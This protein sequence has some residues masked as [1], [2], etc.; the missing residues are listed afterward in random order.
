MDDWN[1]IEAEYETLNRLI[2]QAV[3][4]IHRRYR[5]YVDFDDLKQDCFEWCWRRRRKVEEYLYRDED[6]RASGE[7]A[8]RLALRRRAER[9][10][11]RSKAQAVGYLHT[12]EYFYTRAQVEDLLS[13]YF[14]ED[15]S[16]KLSH[17]EDTERRGRQ[18]PAEGGNV[19]A[20]MADIDRGFKSLLPSDQTLL[21]QLYKRP[22]STPEAL[23]GKDGEHPSPRT[24]R[25]W[26]D[27]AVDRIIVEL[28][29]PSPWWPT[30]AKQYRRDCDY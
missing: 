8:L 2:S 6:G 11:R 10:A 21:I 13:F 3:R 20:L 12:D 26:R 22:T 16:D 15:W 9:A 1:I 28:G 25:R 5:G 19:M 23:A 27:Q 29:G 30:L 4:P 17:N 7:A 14:D 24:I 18:D